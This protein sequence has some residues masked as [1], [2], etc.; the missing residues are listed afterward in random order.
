MRQN[1]NVGPQ[2]IATQQILVPQ[3]VYQ[4]GHRV[5]QKGYIPQEN[6][7]RVLTL[8]P[9]ES[10]RVVSNGQQVVRFANEADPRYFTA[11]QPR[12]LSLQ[13]YYTS[14]RVGQPELVQINRAFQQPQGTAFQQPRSNEVPIHEQFQRYVQPAV[15]LP[16]LSQVPLTDSKF[17]AGFNRYGSSNASSTSNFSF[18]PPPASTKYNFTLPSVTT[19]N[20]VAA[21]TSNYVTSTNVNQFT[22]DYGLRNIAAGIQSDNSSDFL[23]KIDEQLQQSRRQFPSS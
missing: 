20:Y 5:E 8:P 18:V 3:Q 16:A 12:T 10:A 7:Q 14:G 2:Q 4:V 23:R 9:P 22:S 1:E 17:Q 13:E 21:S 11:E 6:E 19:S 15:G